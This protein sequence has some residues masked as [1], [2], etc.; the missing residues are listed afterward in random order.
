VLP[1]ERE[2]ETVVWP[3]GS[4]IDAADRRFAREVEVEEEQQFLALIRHGHDVDLA[5]RRELTDPLGHV[6]H[7]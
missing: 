6:E 1:R 5:D 4:E 3:L 7:R 2:T